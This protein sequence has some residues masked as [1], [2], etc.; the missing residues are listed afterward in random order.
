MKI[1]A[2][3][4]SC[5]DTAIALAN[6]N[7]ISDFKIISSAISSQIEIHKQWGG[8]YPTLAR[9]E[10]QNNLVL[11]LKKVL[12]DAKL[13]KTLLKDKKHKTDVDEIEHILT[14]EKKLFERTSKFLNQY[15]K[16]DIDYISITYGPGLEPCLWT[17]VNFARALSFAWEIPI[18]PINH[19]EAHLFANFVNQPEMLKQPKELF[20]AVFLIVSG[21]HTQ[22]IF[23][24]KLGLYKIIGETRDDAA[25]EAFDKIARVIGLSYPGGPA[26]AKAS[27]EISTNKFTLKLPRP[28]I[29]SN[30][31]DFSFSG[32][33]TAVLYDTKKHSAKTLKTKQ[34]INTMAKESQQAIIDVLVAKTLKAAKAL[35]AKTIIIGGGV[36]ANK[37]LQ[38]L[39][40]KKSS[41]FN[42]IMPEANL[43][44]DNASMV[45]L[46]ACYRLAKSAKIKNW[47]NIKAEANLTL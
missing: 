30:D 10:H 34:Y 28:M 41:G 9:R 33:K 15:Q 19:I 44:T 29:N 16:P 31:F 5:D 42:L 40:A 18:I 35:S 26:I 39:I 21:G 11:V 25:G 4:T 36:A 7:E 24:K 47:K 8:V 6:F 17:G 20:P 13:L 43:C 2:I 22:L 12:K 37:A 27:Q 38:Q 32:L 46:N 1:L 23:I 45:A 3:E 14:R